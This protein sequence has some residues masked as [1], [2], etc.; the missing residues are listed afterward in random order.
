VYDDD[1]TFKR[2]AGRVYGE[3]MPKSAENPARSLD[4]AT[5]IELVF[6]LLVDEERIER[7]FDRNGQLDITEK[8]QDSR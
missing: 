6:I 7:I 4:V 3:R 2:W 1:G 8:H 5:R